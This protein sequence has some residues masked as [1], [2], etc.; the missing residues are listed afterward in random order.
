MEILEDLHWI[1]PGSCSG[2]CWV[3]VAFNMGISREEGHA[4]LFLMCGAI[5]KR[6]SQVKI[7]LTK[8]Y[9]LECAPPMLKSHHL[10]LAWNVGQQNRNR[11]AHEKGNKRDK[12]QQEQQKKTKTRFK[13]AAGIPVKTGR[14]GEEGNCNACL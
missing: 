14:A 5:K 2:D 12:R 3:V 11:Q 1:W 13:E 10:C 4:A 6:S 7:N 9:I 8:M